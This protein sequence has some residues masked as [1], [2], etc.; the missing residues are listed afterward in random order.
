LKTRVGLGKNGIA[1]IASGISGPLSATGDEN[2]PESV[3][4]C[5]AIDIV[6][7]HAAFAPTNETS[8]GTVFAKRFAP[9]SSLPSRALGKKLLMVE[10]LGY[11]SSDQST[12]PADIWDATEALSFRGIPW[13][14]QSS[15]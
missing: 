2:M 9:G 12:H 7:I 13:V 3:W 8:A 11:V 5:D 10:N 6:G 4:G 1:V 14:S 15:S